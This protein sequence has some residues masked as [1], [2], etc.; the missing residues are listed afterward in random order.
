MKAMSRAALLAVTLLSAGVAQA[1]PLTLEEA[2]RQSVANSPQGEASAAR[3]EVLEAARAAADTRPAPTIDGT[4]ENIG[5]GGFNQFQVDATYNQR[6]ERGG[7]RAARIEL[8]EGDIGV[9]QAEALIRRLDLAMQVQELYVEVQAAALDL[10]LA[11]SRVEIAE[12]LQGEVQ[13]RVDDARD[14]LFAGTRARTQLAEAQVDLELAEHALEA[15]TIRLALL[16]GGNHDEISVVTNG[17][18]EPQ[19]VALEYNELS[20]IDLALYEARSQRAEANMRLQD[21]NS[22]TDPTVY[23]GPRVFGSGDVALI[24]GISLP[25]PNRAL[26][27][28]N[29]D[30]AAAERR[31]IDAD[32]A[33]ERFQR[34]REIGFA[35]ERVEEARREAEAIRT[36]VV[37]GAE[38]T[39]REVRDGYNR[40]G[41]TFLDVSTAESALHD[42]RERMVDALAEYHRAKVDLDRLTGRF[43]KLVGGN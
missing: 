41:F 16:T 4:V 30:R 39:L 25:L 22:R 24:A 18:L 8:A 12:R 42:A 31:Q 10:E 13:R 17:F 27:Q 40:G 43:A 28:A 9:A 5:T 6:I 23:G 29:R 3:V 33:V 7:K 14:P 21:A 15:A 32:L 37:P 2:I 26:N 20:S 11:R 38:Q 36:R 35:I 19:A 1:E 34:R